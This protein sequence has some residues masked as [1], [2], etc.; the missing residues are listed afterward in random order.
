[1]KN[2]SCSYCRI[3]M[4]V[5]FLLVC[6]LVVISSSA[7]SDGFDENYEVF[8]G[9]INGDGLVDLY[10]RQKPQILILHGDIATPILLPAPVQ[11]FVL[12]QTSDQEFVL[13]TNLSPSQLQEVRQWPQANIQVTATDL[14]SDGFADLLLQGVASVIVGAFDQRVY[15]SNIEGGAPTTVVA[16][17][18]MAIEYE[19]DE[20][21]RLIKVT[22]SDS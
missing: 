13:L 9:D 11:E 2:S 8:L 18:G 14:D 1:M 7:L 17:P 12:Q 21:G 16:K 20:L 5:K 15:S 19:Y 4:K 10:V 22:S 6:V 3:I